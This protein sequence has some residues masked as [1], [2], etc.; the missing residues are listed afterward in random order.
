MKFFESRKKVFR[1]F[2]AGC[3]IFSA[4]SSFAAK[5][6]YQDPKQPIENRVAD[7]LKRMTIDEKIAQIRHLHSSDLF[8][9]QELDMQKLEKSSGGLC[10]GFVEGFPLTGANCQKNMRQIQKYMVEKTRLGIPI[11][12]VAESL[13]GSVHEG[14][15]IYPQN[16]ALGSTFNTDLA[17]QKAAAIT[18]DLHAQGMHQ[19]LA[20]C[21]DVVR[22]LRWGR[23]E[24]SFGE[25]PLLCGLFGIA[26]V[27][28]YMDH[29]ISPMLKHYG[30]HG[31]PL[32]GL[33]LASVECGVRDLHE[34]YLKP[35]E[36]VIKN[37]PVLAVMSTY[38]SWN[39]V[40]NSASH[41]LLTEVLRN[42]YGFKGYVYSDWGAIE[43]LRM[44]H[45]TAL[46]KK[47]A[48]Y[49]ALTAGLDV[50]ASSNCYPYIKD[51]IAEGRMEESV[52]DQAV[53]RVLYA[54]FKM[55][56]F[57][58]PYGDF[59]AHCK[60]K[61]EKGVKLSKAIADESSVLLKNEN[62]LLPLSASKY[63]KIAV[64]G[65]NADQIQ[66]GDYTW[67]RSNK[68]GIT[69]LQGIRE[70]VGDKA[71]IRYAKGCDLVSLNSEGIAEAVA[72]AQESDVA[73]V[74]C[75]SAS[76]ALAR[77]YKSSTCGEGFDLND[78][79]LTGVQSQLIRQVYE[80]GT[81]VVLVLVTG[82]PFA[83]SWEKENIPAILVQWYAGERCGESVADILFGE[84]SPSGRLPF[85]FPK[86]TGHLP[87]YYNYLPSDKG[88]YKSPGSYTS[89][90][91]D[92][93]FDSPKALWPFGHG[94]TYTSFVYKDMEVDKER[95]DL[96]D[97]IRVSVNVKNI[98]KREGKEVVQLYV[99][100]KV[101]SVVTPIK[102]LRNFKKVTIAPGETQQVDLKVAVDDLYI[103][104]ETNRRVVEAGEFELQVGSSSDNILQTKTVIVGDFKP[105]T[106]NKVK[107]KAI[108]S[109]RQMNVAGEV[110][111][112]Q[113]TLVDNVEIYAK[114]S[115]ECLGKTDSRGRFSI[116]TGNLEIL[117]FKKP[118]Y[119]TLE[120]EVHNQEII[121]VRL[122]NG[123]N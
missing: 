87:V 44:F 50:E 72:V 25:D 15:V 39:H 106:I 22:D 105:S 91:R 49:Q 45:Y 18:E 14:S 107:K 55:G 19:V 65:P 21:I 115:G 60:M 80:T 86:S 76:A 122:N 9:E 56:L 85:S 82:K 88:Y 101:S 84:V 30:P 121:N 109:S 11:F 40:P 41:Y 111:D 89:P 26:E 71:E 53:A 61:D 98:G 20:P 38:N 103:V 58:D 75:G 68:D 47:E 77:D 7:L 57:E 118:G 5:K 52:L 63:K 2:A 99:R 8:N 100:D 34:I 112:V 73:I 116:R 79:N 33:N 93:V 67:T 64:I 10:W 54:K 37:V 97:T 70:L 6:P 29:G 81:P 95:Y 3:L 46:D 92:Y 32:S 123:E 90:G 69:P 108:K 16:V 36:M 114:S 48:A 66:F 24:E 119:Q 102:Q 23:V 28:G 13:H 83:I 42:Q 12:T 110:R 17:Y 51:L 94:L 74:F 27:K 31:N 43:M 78:L 113:A 62:N 117:A 1:L 120:I 96:G 4:V 35:F 104:D 59:Y